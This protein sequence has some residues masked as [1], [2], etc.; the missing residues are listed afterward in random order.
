MEKLSC[1]E[2]KW[3]KVVPEVSRKV[4]NR[5][6]VSQLIL[7]YH[8]CCLGGCFY[9]QHAIQNMKS[10]A[11]GNLFWC[12][13][14]MFLQTFLISVD[15]LSNFVQCIQKLA[16]VYKNKYL[17]WNSV[18]SDKP[19]HSFSTCSLEL[20]KCWPVSPADLKRFRFGSMLGST[21]KILHKSKSL[22]M[23]VVPSM[24]LTLLCNI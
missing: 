22:M 6:Q 8:C 16:W 11:G 15:W 12:P 18:V 13:V 20:G 7:S 1:M 24:T 5:T 14:C 2:T 23:S 4:R 3:W 19:Y 17:S 9:F 10:N 21:V